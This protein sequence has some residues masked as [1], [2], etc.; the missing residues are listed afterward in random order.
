MPQPQPATLNDVL[1]TEMLS[2]RSPRAANL[3]AE[4]Q[5]MRS[6]ARQMVKAPEVMLQNLVE[7]AVELCQAGT[8]GVSLLETIDGAEVFRWT[9]LAGT[10]SQNA[11]GTIPRSFSPCG[12]CLDRGTPV[13]F[14]HPAQ[15]FTN[16]QVANI[17][18]VEGLVLPLVAEDHVFGTIWIVSHDEQRH[19]DSEDV[20]I[21]TS[22]ADFTALALRLN[23]RQ[24]GELLAKNVQLEAEIVERKQ[25][26]AQGRDAQTRLQLSLTGANL[27][28]WTYNVSTDEFWADDRAKQ[29]HGHAPH[30]V[31]TFQEA[32]ANIHPDDLDRAE[33][34]VQA[35]QTRSKL[36]IE[37]RVIWRDGSVH[38]IASHAE[39]MPSDDPAEGIFY[40][41]AQDIT[42]QKQAEAALRESEAQLRLFVTASSYI[43]YK[44]SADWREMRRLEGKNFLASTENPSGT[45]LEQYIPP[46]DQPGV[47]VAIQA[48]IRT[49]STF[50][51]E[52]R[53]IQQDGT[54]G[55]TFSRAIPLLNAQHEIVE[56]FGAASNISGRRHYEANLA[57]LAE[58][59]Q[60]L[61]HLTNID[62]TMNAVGEKIAAHLG[63]SA[64]A[65]AELNETAEVAVI[66]YGWHRSDV[67]SPLGTY[68]MEEFVTPEILQ[69]CRAGEAVVIRDVF[70]DPM[71]DGEQYAA[72]NIG[73]FV[74]IPLVRDGEWRFLLAV[75]HAESYDWRDDEIEITRELANRIWTR[76]ER[77]RAEVSLRESEEKY[78]SLFT[79]M[80][81]GFCIIE[82]VETLEGQPND[83]RYLTVNPAFERHT[84][85]HD[86]VGKTLR[87]CVPDTEQHIMDIYDDVVR[88]EQPQQFE[89]YVSALDRW[90]EAE[91]FPAQVPGQIAVLFSN[92][93]DRKQAE[94]VLRESE[95]RQVFLLELSDTL[96]AQPNKDAIAS[97]SLVLLA[98]RLHL[99]RAY[100]A[101]IY[102]AEGRG[103][104]GPE[105]RRP[106]LNPISGV[107]R[108][109]DFPEGFR[110]VEEGTFWINNIA[111]DP[112]L[113]DL[114]RQ[115]LAAIDLT[116][117]IVGALRKGEKNL[118]WALV[119]ASTK[120]RQWTSG[121]VALIE[122]TAE[123]TWAAVERA[124]AEE[125]L[126]CAAEMDVFR[127]ELSD[128]LRSLS[129]AVEIQATVTRS[130]MNFFRADRCYY[131]EIIDGSAII[132][133]DASQADL[134]SVVGAYPLEN[135]PIFKAMID[136]GQPFVVQDAH[137]TSMLDEELRQTCLQLQIISFINVP[138]IKQGEAVG[139]LCITQGTP[140]N[141]TQFEMD[142]AEEVADRAWATIERTRA[143][144]NLREAELQQVREQ[145]AR[146][147]E[148]Q[149]AETLAELDRTKTAFFSNI[150]HEF[151]TPLTL[152]LAPLQDAIR[153]VDEWRG[154][155]VGESKSEQVNPSTLKHQ[156]ELAHRNSL[157]LLKLVNTLLDF[158]RIEAGR[159]EAVYEP[160]D[161]ALVTAELASVF[162]SAIEQAGLRLIVD[163]PP[164]P[165]SVYVDREMWEKIVLNLIS[166][167][168]KFTFAGEI[169]VRLHAADHRVI[170]QIQ[171]TGTGIAPEHLPHL[172]ERFYQVRGTQARTHEGSGIGLALV[173]ELI[174]FHGG[175]IEVSSTVG[176]GTCF[177]IALPFGTDH[178]PNDRLHRVGDRNVIRTLTSTLSSAAAYVEEGRSLP[179]KGN[180]DW[181]TGNE[182]DQSVPTPN[183]QPPLSQAHVLCVDD[184][185][186]MREYLMHILSNHVQ[187]EAVAD[188][189]A[190]LAAIQTQVP[191][192]IL[193]DVMMPG[194]D[195]FG[196]LQTLRADPHTREIPI[197]LLSA[198]AGEEAIVE[199]LEAGADDYLIKPFSVQ[200]LVSRVKAL[201]QMAQLRGEALHEAR[202][203]IR[204][205]DELLSTVS[206]ELNTPLVSILGWTR[207]LR[208][209]PTNP[210]MLTKALD[211]IERNAMLQT[212]LVQDLLD[213][214]RI[215]SGKLHLSCQ[216]VELEAIIDTAIA[217]VHHLAEEKGVDLV[218]QSITNSAQNS[219]VVVMGD[220]HRLQQILCNL[221]TNA[222][223][224]TPEAGSVTVE[225]SVVDAK[226]SADVAYAQIQVIDTGIGISADF[227]PHVFDPFQQAESEHSAKGLGLGLTIA[228]HLAKLHNGTI[229]AQSAGTGQGA[230]LIVRLPRISHGWW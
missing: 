166:N 151:R 75:Y 191:D 197:I 117:F 142:L 95:E 27:G 36:Q 72:L 45:W 25:A 50:E 207:L 86:V 66:N 195:G 31:H 39:F 223:K 82:K 145:A 159:M 16:L 136:A 147:Q 57:F 220:R 179:V 209:N 97:A 114:D 26:E 91:V 177:T 219:A 150:S 152:I 13:L 99:D 225:Q 93:S 188:G 12:V 94:R 218:W 34:F 22:L 205:K 230:T 190:A 73:S 194:I 125:Q 169:A 122:D 171:D 33:A 204:R 76:L 67:P 90:I 228:Q 119:A 165:E 161:L 157:R 129:D 56:W 61:A 186:D 43:V 28:V 211:T 110:Q 10:S 226:T 162:R 79:A 100:I 96:R 41:I 229:Q 154:A 199:G 63:L 47:M 89:Y 9:V 54:I 32:G 224:F 135:S 123:R 5:A 163:C 176:A 55:W 201:L 19:F 40:G 206:H 210:T 167:A 173:H 178:L 141:W 172:F 164:L 126:R 58:I 174:R 69:R 2:Q 92:I 85:M 146:E 208:S 112:S 222:I 11:G 60:D 149:R 158:S 104:V 148:R 87:E 184:N 175:T 216:P 62:E 143:E 132:R 134:P 107:L 106:D 170:L 105:Y 71:T 144:A 3:Q 182:E 198:R 130:T 137:K 35:I 203:T 64:C 68:R 118:T 124:C 80:N 217:T 49:K 121:E 52:H 24:T 185:A 44:M 15:Y 37:Y 7:L 160:I 101:A 111:D 133:R 109:S 42:E 139:I 120:P 168:F 200:E 14:S 38:W 70:N 29:L 189:A 192:L 181:R 6:L 21:M 156:L 214:S 23:Q 83:F 81:Q 88:T 212:Q 202:T 103:I 193:S 127:V 183:S 108:P 30:E 187:V 51:L 102:T 153:R 215:T 180:G 65:F 74:S 77:A 53:V 116:A 84:G 140:R 115:S 113:S 213:M 1:I 196:L 18:I 20:R 227:L 128:A 131:C 8:A 4:N 155:W 59:S 48:A 138:V 98:K 221:L 17:S 78:R 46:E